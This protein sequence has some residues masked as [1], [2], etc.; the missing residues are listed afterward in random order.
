MNWKERE[1]GRTERLKKRG[2]PEVSYATRGRD[3]ADLK[4]FFCER[5]Q[6]KICHLVL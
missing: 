4:T 5:H 3:A 6:A 2:V 1:A